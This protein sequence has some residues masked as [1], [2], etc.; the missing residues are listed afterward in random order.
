MYGCKLSN[1][2]TK[3][4]ISVFLLFLF[5]NFSLTFIWIL[6][7]GPKLLYYCHIIL[8][9]LLAN[10]LLNQQ[11]CTKVDIYMKT[12]C[13]CSKAMAQNEQKERKLSKFDSVR[14]LR[15]LK[16]TRTALIKNTLKS[17]R[18]KTLMKAPNVWLLYLTF[19]FV[20]ISVVVTK[21]VL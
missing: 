20:L 15:R 14:R 16:T 2:K 7:L 19:V 13:N 11:Y 17:K 3:N 12:F 21:D 8:S 10:N 1:A 9:F 6:V 18:Y 4:N 5:Y